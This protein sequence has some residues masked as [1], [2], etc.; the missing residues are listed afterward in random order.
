MK[1]VFVLALLGLLT[2]CGSPRIDTSSNGALQDSIPQVS[3]SLSGPDRDEFDELI[4]LARRESSRPDVVAGRVI[5]M[6]ELMQPF[7][8]MTGKEMLAFWREQDAIAKEAAAQ[9]QAEK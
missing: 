8:G 5:P 4:E 9:R 2:G 7:H 6:T 3:R 1:K